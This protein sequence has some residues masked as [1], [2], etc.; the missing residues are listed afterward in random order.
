MRDAMRVKP[1]VSL[2]QLF[3]SDRPVKI[4]PEAKFIAFQRLYK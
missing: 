2:S 4:Y 3:L 1:S